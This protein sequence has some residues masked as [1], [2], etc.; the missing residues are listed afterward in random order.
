MSIEVKF[1]PKVLIK[2]VSGKALD[3]K[4]F[5]GILI[6]GKLTFLERTRQMKSP[7][8]SRRAPKIGDIIRTDPQDS[9]QTWAIEEVTG[10]VAVLRNIYSG[11]ATCKPLASF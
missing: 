5:Y 8:K 1:I 6:I 11:V 9:W 10:T 3:R 2:K 7:P 4:V